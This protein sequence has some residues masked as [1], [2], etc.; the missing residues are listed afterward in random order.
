MRYQ[1]LVS[2]LARYLDINSDPIKIGLTQVPPDPIPPFPLP[3][4]DKYY[5]FKQKNRPLGKM[6]VLD[7]FLIKFTFLK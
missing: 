1:K 2:Q 6:F 4:M 7:L 3:P 5:L